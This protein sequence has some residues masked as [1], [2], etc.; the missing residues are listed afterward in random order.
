M[1][2][3]QYDIEAARISA[4]PRAERFE[5]LMTFP[6]EN[7]LLTKV[8]M[9]L[10]KH[11]VLELRSEHGPRSGKV[12]SRQTNKQTTNQDTKDRTRDRENEAAPT[13]ALM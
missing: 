5:E 13:L 12:S 9:E 11:V 10:D 4:L 1:D 6:K 3:N 8:G 2:Q 7:C